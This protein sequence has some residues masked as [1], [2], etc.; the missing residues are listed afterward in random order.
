MCAQRL[1]DPHRTIYLYQRAFG[2]K[3]VKGLRT[4]RRSLGHPVTLPDLPQAGTRYVGSMA[5]LPD[6]RVD[7]RPAHS[8]SARLSGVIS[9][10]NRDSRR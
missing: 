4:Y 2:E 7:L 9:V 5:M 3:R 8:G 1:S 6:L 10:G